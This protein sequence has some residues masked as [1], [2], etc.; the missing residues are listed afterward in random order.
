MF[1]NLLLLGLAASVAFS[2]A[3]VL[4]QKAGPYQI[5]LRLPVDGLFSAEEMQIEFR[6][7]DASKEDPLTGFAPVIRAKILSEIDMPSMSGMP[8]IRETSHPEGVPGDYGLHPTFAHGGEYR[9]RLTIEPPGASAFTVEFKL[10]VGDERPRR[11]KIESPYKLKADRSGNSLA[12]RVSGPEGAVKDFDIVHEKPMHLI[13][14]SKD[15]KSFAH[16]HPELNSDGSFRLAEIPMSGDLRFFADFAPR[17]KGAQVLTFAMKVD[18]KRTAPADRILKPAQLEPKD[19]AWRAGKTQ[20]VLYA[21]GA[22]LA[23]L[24][25]YLGALG[26]LVMIHE[27]AETYV[28]AHPIDDPSK[29][30]FLARPPK[31]GKYRAWV[32]TQS[33]GQVYRQSFEIEV[34]GNGTR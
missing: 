5:T 21:G 24:E 22:A 33:K 8:V 27:D 4:E 7:V 17:G 18:G 16:V 12:L 31:A 15:L 23:D 19:G 26:H 32:E 28:H 14:V 29:L 6:L 11:G 13:V 20:E 1:R 3:P 25:P 30:I 10:P 34:P 2:Q 9:L